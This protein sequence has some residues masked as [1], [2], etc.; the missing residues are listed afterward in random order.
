MGGRQVTIISLSLLK[1][2]YIILFFF[3]IVQII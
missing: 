1:V 3:F 2:G